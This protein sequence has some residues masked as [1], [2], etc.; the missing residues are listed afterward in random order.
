MVINISHLANLYTKKYGSTSYSYTKIRN[1]LSGVKGN[2][3]K[4]EIQQLRQVLK[5][6]VTETDSVLAKLENQQ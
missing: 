2:A 3:T 4:K 6:A 1:L 5:A